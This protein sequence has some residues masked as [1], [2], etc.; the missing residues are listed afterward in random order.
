M[1]CTTHFIDLSAQTF[2]FRLNTDGKHSATLWSLQK[3]PVS[4][5][6]QA[7][8]MT[9]WTARLLAYAEPA[10]TTEVLNLTSP[11]NGLALVTVASKVFLVDDVPTTIA[12]PWGV[13]LN[14]SDANAA[15]IIANNN[16]LYYHLFLTD[17]GNNELPMFAKGTLSVKGFANG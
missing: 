4:G 11:I 17:A 14:L 5:V 9:G 16:L 2:N 13:A 8:D 7:R 3:N 6:L 15:S 10:L 12:N 1:N